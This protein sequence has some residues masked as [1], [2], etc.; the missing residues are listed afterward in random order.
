MDW[1][2]EKVKAIPYLEG[3]INETLRLKPAVPGGVPRVTPATGLWVDDVYIPGDTNVIVPAYAIHRDPR[4]FEGPNEFIPE[5]WLDESWERIKNKAAYAP[6]SSGKCNLWTGATLLILNALCT[7]VYG[8]IGKN[9]ALMQL[10][11]IISRV[12][13]NF[14]LWFAPGET[15]ESFD[16]D[17]L[18][19]FTLNLPPLQLTLEDRT[20]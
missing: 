16:K 20:R 11:S 5:R 14:N 19:T 3:I 9:L 13:L 8:C 15:G 4:Y 7:G 6:F 17:A 2:Y 10:R 1:S 12:A 18:D